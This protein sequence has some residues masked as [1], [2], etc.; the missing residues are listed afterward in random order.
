MAFSKFRT[1]FPTI[2]FILVCVLISMIVLNFFH[3]NM[4][5][6]NGIKVL[7]RTLTVEGFKEGA[8]MSK[9]AVVALSKELKKSK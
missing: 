1:L 5:D 6:N 4:N 7:N 9:K 8:N 2:I 3:V